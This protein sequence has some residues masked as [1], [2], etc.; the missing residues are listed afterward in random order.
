[1]SSKKYFSYIRVSTQRQGQHGTSLVEQQAAID[2]FAGSWNLH[3]TERFEE[4]ETAA[5]Q[6]RPVFLEM[7]KQLKKG[8]ADGV[9]IHKIDRSARNLKDWAALGSLIDIGL[10]VHFAGE[11]LDLNSRG[12]RL[13][14]DIQAVVA[15]D[16]I[17]N[18]REETK[19]GIY[20]RLKQGLFP[21]PAVIGFLDGGR[22]QP[23]RIDPNAGPIIRKAFELYATGDWGLMPL[24]DKL[25][26]LGLRNKAGNSLSVNGLSTI[27]HNSFYMGL[28]KIEKTGEVFTGIH[29]PIVSKALFDQVQEVF[30]GKRA[31][32]QRRHFFTFRQII[33]CQNC[34]YFLI[35]ELQKG[36]IYYRCRSKA[37]LRQCLKEETVSDALLS[38]FEKMQLTNGEYRYLR[39]SVEIGKSKLEEES[40]E[41]KKLIELQRNKIKERLSRLADIL[42]DG[43][44]DQETYFQKKNELIFEECSL[45]EKLSNYELG[46]ESA[47]QRFD[48]FLELASSAYLSYKGATA[49]DKRDF[50]KIATA[51]LTSDGKSV[52]IKLKK[53]FQIV[54]DRDLITAGSP[55]RGGTRTL[56]ALLSQLLKFFRDNP[57]QSEDSKISSGV[58][59]RSPMTNNSSPLHQY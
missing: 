2:R 50:V 1:M 20:G 26:K 33:R 25:N 56:P 36:H 17:R 34:N 15:S 7:L 43:I 51:N 44:I 12:G 42:V 40:E 31:K 58:L 30:A 52:S 35:A 37:C 41:A 47:V 19:K 46:Q 53:P 11:S 4:R 32:K 21:F 16:Y 45:K 28:I 3:I 22:G 38:L 18:L 29:A 23:K 48:E 55:R 24:T 5:K 54:A 14:A 10:E 39:K 59:S 6:G 57:V 8:S 13:S 9:I 27:L 49:A